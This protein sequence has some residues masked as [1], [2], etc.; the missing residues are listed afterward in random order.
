VVFAA[1]TDS[2][3]ERAHSAAKVY[4]AFLRDEV[5]HAVSAA[6]LSNLAAI[7]R[8]LADVH[9]G[10]DLEPSF[11]LSSRPADE[12]DRRTGDDAEGGE[13]GEASRAGE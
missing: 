9:G 12:P 11:E 1:L 6:E 10:P 5:L 8:R 7:A 3:L 2:G 13:G 4:R